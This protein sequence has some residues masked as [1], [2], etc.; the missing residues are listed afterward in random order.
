[1]HCHSKLQLQ[2]LAAAGVSKATQPAL[3]GS[4][5]SRSL[6]ATADGCSKPFSQEA[7]RFAGWRVSR[8]SRPGCCQPQSHLTPSELS[9]APS[10]QQ[11]ESHADAVPRVL[12]GHL[13]PRLRLR[14]A[15]CL[16]CTCRAWRTALSSSEIHTLAQVQP[17]N[18][19]LQTFSRPFEHSPVCRHSCLP[20]TQCAQDCQK[21]L[22]SSCRLPHTQMQPYGALRCPAVRTWS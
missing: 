20:A 8:S 18:A 1:M 3:D 21:R 13:A 14:D 2:L 12:L 7:T 5:A 4:Q 17:A 19:A 16:R 22:C 15:Q 10:R 9:H 11:S 6:S